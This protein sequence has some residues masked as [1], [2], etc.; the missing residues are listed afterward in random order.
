MQANAMKF[1]MPLKN[2]LGSCCIDFGINQTDRS[3]N[4]DLYLGDQVQN[5]SMSYSWSQIFLD[6]FVYYELNKQGNS[7][8]TYTKCKY[9]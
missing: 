4:I 1:G 8:K 3:K 5:P 9:S 7:I 2:M 6:I